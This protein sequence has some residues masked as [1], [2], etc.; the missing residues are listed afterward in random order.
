MDRI[1]HLIDWNTRKCVKCGEPIVR[2]I[3]NFYTDSEKKWDELVD[4]NV[5]A[6]CVKPS[7]E[8]K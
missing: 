6:P 2:D 7:A 3:Y 5:Y 4:F 1:I 8:A